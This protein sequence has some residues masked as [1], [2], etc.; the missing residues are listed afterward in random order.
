MISDQPMSHTHQPA[1][2]ATEPGFDALLGI[3]QD[4]LDLPRPIISHPSS[5]SRAR[6]FRRT[7]ATRSFVSS[8]CGAR[9]A[10]SS[11]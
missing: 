10:H 6:G 9:G 1:Q 7:I 4:A 8:I 3:V 5:A 11:S 2:L